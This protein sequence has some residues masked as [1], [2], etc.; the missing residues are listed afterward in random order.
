MKHSETEYVLTFVQSS[1]WSK[2][3]W[4]RSY[5]QEGGEGGDSNTSLESLD[6]PQW[7]ALG[8]PLQDKLS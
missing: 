8:K 1:E 3:V 6:M 4:L 5:Y 7:A 2:W